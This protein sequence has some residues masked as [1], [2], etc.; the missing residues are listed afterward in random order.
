MDLSLTVEELQTRGSVVRKLLRP[1]SKV[2]GGPAFEFDR[3][4]RN[5]WIGTYDRPRLDKKL[6]DLTFKTIA[7]S[8]RGNYYEQWKKI[9]PG[10]WRI[11]KAYLNLL[12][13]SESTRSQSKYVSLHCD[14][15]E[16]ED[17]PH[18]TYKRQPH[19]HI[20]NAT[21][22][23]HSHL[24]LTGGYFD[25]THASVRSMSDAIDWSIRMVKDEVL[26]RRA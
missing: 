9:K 23:A 26:S 3:R 2:E 6:Q 19:L 14:P 16:P 24:A 25:K 12:M 21:D 13:I 18:F 15:H 17:Q 22:L 8:I 11:E 20:Q 10:K 4:G 1:I 7:R 5:W